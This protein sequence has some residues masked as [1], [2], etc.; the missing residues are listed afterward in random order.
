MLK[1]G[2]PNIWRAKNPM[3]EIFGAIIEA[4]S[5]MGVVR[6]PNAPCGQKKETFKDIQPRE[7]NGRGKTPID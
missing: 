7:A 4:G 6:H 1:P 3:Q 2:L 5:F